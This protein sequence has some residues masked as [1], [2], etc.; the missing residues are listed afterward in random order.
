MITSDK[1]MIKFDGSET[2]VM[3]DAMCIL[4]ILYRMLADS[5]GEG[6]AKE[7]VASMGE[8]AVAHEERKAVVKTGERLGHTSVS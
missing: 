7:K 2:E 3:A 1:G 5:H 4:G 6:Y 8:L